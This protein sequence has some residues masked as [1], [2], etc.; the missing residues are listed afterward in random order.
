MIK[1]CYFKF[2]QMTFLFTDEIKILENIFLYFL[3]PTLGLHLT[4]KTEK[5]QSQLFRKLLATER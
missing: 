2:S 4:T 3:S 1:Y 5:F